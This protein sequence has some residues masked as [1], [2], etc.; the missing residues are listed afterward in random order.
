VSSKVEPFAGLL[1]DGFTGTKVSPRFL[2]G[3]PKGPRESWRELDL[4]GAHAA[5]TRHHD[6][7]ECGPNREALPRNLASV[8]E[9]PLKAEPSSQNQS[10]PGFR[11]FR[12]MN[13]GKGKSNRTCLTRSM[14]WPAFQ[15]SSCLN[16]QGN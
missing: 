14:T 2:L 8:G 13:Q 16:I 3:Q 7:I 1:G 6:R 9:R 5:S 11:Q 10:R 15:S 4:S 12:Q